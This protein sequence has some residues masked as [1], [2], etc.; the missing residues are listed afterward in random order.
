MVRIIA[1]GEDAHRLEL[2]DDTV[3]GWVRERRLG[4]CCVGD[5]RQALAAAAAARCAL[6]AVLRRQFPG[7]PHREPALDRLRVV[8]DGADERICDG[9]WRLAR[10]IREDASPALEGAFAIE[11]ELPSFANDGVAIAAAQLVGAAVERHARWD[12]RAAEAVA[13][14]DPRLPRS[15]PA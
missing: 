6:E 15:A 14:L 5:E 12:R 1:D 11:L 10:L 3:V 2:R 9:D 4:F 7:W 13:Q 8:L